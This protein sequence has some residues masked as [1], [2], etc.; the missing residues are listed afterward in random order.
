MRL[1]G[2]V[3]TAFVLA[4]SAC[5]QM[6]SGVPVQVIADRS[7]F[8]MI[9]PVCDG[10]RV[11]MLAVYDPK[12]GTPDIVQ[13]QPDQVAG[14]SLVTVEVDAATLGSGVLLPKWNSTRSVAT[15]EG[16]SLEL[17]DLRFA[18]RIY[19]YQTSFD[20]GDLS[21]VASDSFLVE[22]SLGTNSNLTISETTE[23]SARAV[24]DG[25]CGTR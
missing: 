25:W 17:H 19:D 6:E 20:L 4:I 13:V 7:G 9:F 11:Q 14:D 18:V 1:N 12:S 16:D 21:S 22:G 2:I 3:A 15:R 8:T 5:G 24:L 23:D 10:D